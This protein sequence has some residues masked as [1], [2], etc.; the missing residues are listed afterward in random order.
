MKFQLTTRRTKIIM[1]MVW[2]YSLLLFVPWACF[3]DLV[4]TPYDDRQVVVLGCEEQWPVP[5]GAKWFLVFVVVLLVYV[6]P[7]LLISYCY[8]QIFLQV[9]KRRLVGD[10]T[11]Y[12]RVVN[13][14]KIQ[15]VK[16]LLIVVLIFALSWLPLYMLFLVITFSPQESIN[17]HVITRL[18]PIVQW[19]ITSNSAINPCLYAWLN[20]KY[21][22]GFLAILKSIACYRKFCYKEGR[23]AIC[24]TSKRYSMT[25]HT[26][27]DGETTRFNSSFCATQ[28]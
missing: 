28:I 23:S 10:A 18:V 9:W 26:Q 7:L 13:K 1:T 2:L 3:F 16:M 12:E 5:G 6:I 4:K 27:M 22:T 21:R 19:I 11:N 24:Q 14:Q 25:E 15:V 17:W 8:L 20:K